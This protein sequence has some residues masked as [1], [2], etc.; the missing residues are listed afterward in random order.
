[1]SVVAPS[2][3]PDAL[4]P[5]GARS[6]TGVGV[7]KRPTR[8]AGQ[9]GSLVRPTLVPARVLPVSAVPV[10]AVPV[11]AVPVSGDAARVRRP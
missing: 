7:V 9:A 2:V 10:P 8:G 11:S 6:N 3:E 1:M 5:R 4:A